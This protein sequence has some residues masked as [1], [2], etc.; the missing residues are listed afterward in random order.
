[1]RLHRN[2]LKIFDSA[3]AHHAASRLLRTKFNAFKPIDSDL[4]NSESKQAA[5][6][7]W[8]ENLHLSVEVL[9]GFAAELY[10]KGFIQIYGAPQKRIYGLYEFFTALPEDVQSKLQAHAEV[11]ELDESIQ[12]HLQK[13][14]DSFARVRY[15]HEGFPGTDVLSHKILKI[16]HKHL[17]ELVKD[18]TPGRFSLEGVID[19]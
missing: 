2:D 18:R 6:E 16:F 17:M 8:K 3:V 10:L 13:V 4:Q 5:L 14:A 15:I 1:M 11:L 9:I 7:P 19:E 12:Q